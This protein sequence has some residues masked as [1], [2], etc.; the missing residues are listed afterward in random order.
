MIILVFVL[1]ACVVPG[2]AGNITVINASFEIPTGLVACGSTFV[3]ACAYSSMTPAG[4]SSNS[5]ANSGFAGTF[6]P[7]SDPSAAFT[8]LAGSPS[9]AFINGPGNGPGS[10]NS[11]ANGSLTQV[12]GVTLANL[13]YILTVDLGWRNDNANFVSEVDLIIGSTPFKAIGNTPAKG[14]F[15]TF[16]A[17]FTA[18]TSGQQI[19]IQ[20]LNT[21]V[22]G[23]PGQAVFDNVN[24]NSIPE[25]GTIAMTAI[26]MGMLAFHFRRRRFV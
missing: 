7:G 20:L 23:L 13:T 6:Q 26:G 12:V 4:W 10:G 15:S 21:G 24:L 8:T 3:T 16:T 17:T 1:L 25:P 9:V 19:M 22:V 11:I 14:K 18:A 2:F 5:P